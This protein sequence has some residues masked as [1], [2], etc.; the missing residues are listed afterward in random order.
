LASAYT[1]ST[2]DFNTLAWNNDCSKMIFQFKSD[3]M[4]I[5]DII[6]NQ[7]LSILPLNTISSPANIADYWF[8]DSF[9]KYVGVA[10]SN[11]TFS[12]FNISLTVNKL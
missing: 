12:I 7:T 9:D 8:I 1:G 4:R 10:L 3:G 5:V 6:T 11:G 2:R